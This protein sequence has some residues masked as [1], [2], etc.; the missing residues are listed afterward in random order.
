MSLG[1]VPSDTYCESWALS[2]APHAFNLTRYKILLFNKN[3]V[4]ERK[5][6]TSHIRT[7]FPVSDVAPPLLSRFVWLTPAQDFDG[8]DGDTKA[9]REYFKK[10]FASLSRRTDLKVRE[11]DIYIQYVIFSLF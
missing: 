10:A 1:A 2:W 3:D 11:R 5:V 8:E 9:G 4:F 7:Y 6:R